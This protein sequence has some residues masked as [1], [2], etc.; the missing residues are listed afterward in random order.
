MLYYMCK[1]KKKHAFGFILTELSFSCAHRE[2]EID[3][4]VCSNYYVNYH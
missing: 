2:T 1:A 3:S 4:D